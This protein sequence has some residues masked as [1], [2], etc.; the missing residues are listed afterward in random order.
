MSNTAGRIPRD[1][2]W[3]DRD[4]NVLDTADKLT[5][6]LDKL[7]ELQEDPEQLAQLRAD[8]DAEAARRARGA[9]RRGTGEDCMT[10][11]VVTPLTGARPQTF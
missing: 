8:V 3:V 6:H 10:E 5:A 7:A 4:G 11:L 1:R 9:A 2:A